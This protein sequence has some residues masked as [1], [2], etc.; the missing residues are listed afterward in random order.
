MINSK[1]TYIYRI[2]R[3]MVWVGGFFILA[4]A[5][6]ICIEVLM[7]AAFGKSFAGVDEVSG[8]ALAISTTWACGYALLHKSH[9][10]IDTLYFLFPKSLR[11]FLDIAALIALIAFVSLIT[12]RGSELAYLSAQFDA[13]SMT[14]LATPLW[15]PQALWVVGLFSFLVV[16]LSLLWRA[17]SALKTGQTDLISKLVGPVSIEEELNEELD[18][19][20][21]RQ[22]E[23]EVKS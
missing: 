19:M 16:I 5:A 12:Y 9:V 23:T 1:E 15:I 14:P 10:R 3:V 8:Y 2:S 4:A 7:R 20:T 18:D 22:N 6:V 11:P 13:H 17:I 21:R